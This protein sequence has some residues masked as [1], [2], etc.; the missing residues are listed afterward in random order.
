MAMAQ[1]AGEL[2]KYTSLTNELLVMKKAVFDSFL[3]Q[4]P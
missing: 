2:N 3:D 1:I 4:L